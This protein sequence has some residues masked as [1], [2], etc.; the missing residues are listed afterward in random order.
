MA[1]SLLFFIAKITTIGG[2]KL[3]VIKLHLVYR[4]IWPLLILCY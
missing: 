3:Q 1:I 4:L 2:T